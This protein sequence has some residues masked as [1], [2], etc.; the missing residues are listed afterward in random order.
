VLHVLGV[1]LE[2]DSAKEY[3]IAFQKLAVISHQADLGRRYIYIA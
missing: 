1:T 3:K 2:T